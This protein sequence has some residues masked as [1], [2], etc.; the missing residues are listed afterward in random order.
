MTDTTTEKTKR[1]RWPRRLLI[2]LGVLAALIVL[3]VLLFPFISGL[4][5]PMAASAIEDATGRTAKVEALSVNLLTSRATVRGVS[6]ME[7]DGTT[8]FAGIQRLDADFGLLPLLGGRI[9]LPSVAVSGVRARVFVDEQ[10]RAN[11]QSILDHMA[12]QEDEEEDED[13][14]GEEK[15]E[16]LPD[17]QAAVRVEDVQIDYEDRRKDLAAELANPSLRCLIEGLEKISY[18][19][20]PGTVRFAAAGKPSGSGEGNW[21]VEG[22]AAVEQK[23]G[24]LAVSSEGTFE[25]SELVLRREEQIISQGKS[26]RLSHQLA[27][28]AEEGLHVSRLDLESEFLTARMSEFRFADPA[29]LPGLIGADPRVIERAGLPDWNARIEGEIRLQGLAQLLSALQ[30]APGLQHATGTIRYT[31][32]LSGRP[33]TTMR[34]DFGA[35]SDGLEV[36]ARPL[37][38][39]TSV[40]LRLVIS[41]LSQQAD[42]SVDLRTLATDG[43]HELRVTGKTKDAEL[44]TMRQKWQTPPVL[45][46]ARLPIPLNHL[47]NHLEADLSALADA[48]TGL[49]PARTRLSGRL[50]SEDTVRRD[51]DGRLSAQGR[52]ELSARLT[53]PHLPAPLPLNLSGDRRITLDQPPDG[54]LPDVTVEKLTL[55]STGSDLLHLDASGRITFSGDSPADFTLELGSDLAAAAPYL[56]LMDIPLRMQGRV[57]QNLHVESGGSTVRVTGSGGLRDLRLVGT[58]LPRP[59]TLSQARWR[60]D[61]AVL[62]EGGKPRR[63][64]LAPREKDAFELVLPGMRCTVGGTIDQI[65]L[66]AG[67]C[68]VE[69]LRTDLETDF[70]RLPRST[71]QAPLNAMLPAATKELSLGGTTTAT[72]TAS[73]NWPGRLSGRLDANLSPMTLRLLGADGQILAHKDETVP[74][75][76]NVPFSLE[77]GPDGWTALVSEL[78]ARLADLAATGRF[79]IDDRFALSGPDGG[80]RFALTAG[81]LDSL[82]QMLPPA[83]LLQPAGGAVDLAAERMR[84]A[85]ADQR[86]HGRISGEI[87]LESLS[88]ARAPELVTLLRPFLEDNTETEQPAEDADAETPEGANPGEQP[89]TSAP[90]ELPESL[91]QMLRGLTADVT[92]KVGTTHL[93][94]DDTVRDLACAINFDGKKP[95]DQLTMDLTGQV[96]PDA[97]QP[98]T[99]EAGCTADISETAPTF[100]SDYRIERLP[101]TTPMLEAGRRMTSLKTGMDLFESVR[102]DTAR[103]MSVDAVGD[104]RWRGLQWATLS[105]S[106]TS[107]GG[108]SADLPGGEFHL[109][110]DPARLL[111]SETLE[112]LTQGRLKPLTGALEKAREDKQRLNQRVENIR[113]T[114]DRI[115]GTVEKLQERR[116]NIKKTIDR[117]KPLAAFSEDAQEKLDE[118]KEKVD[119]FSGDLEK[120][121]KELGEEQDTRSK[122]QKELDRARER[123]D[124][125]QKKIENAGTGGL[126]LEKMLEFSFQGL[127]LEL[128]LENESPWPG[129]ASA[130]DLAKYAISRIR[131]KKVQFRPEKKLIPGFAGWIDLAGDYGIRIT[132]SPAALEDLEKKVPPL[133]RALREGGLVWTPT[134]LKLPKLEP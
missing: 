31:A 94:P 88:L 125:L 134:G 55:A 21:T 12:A 133:G 121:K 120:K 119:E 95:A 99:I 61:L 112:K 46:D 10:G 17:V 67:S 41:S 45:G 11:Y 29:L 68:T 115:D 100:R 102:F 37:H 105:R 44:L 56:D 24:S 3:I 1:R 2:A 93:G 66:A 104:A 75:T 16:A 5:A 81:K 108:I 32:G 118:W 15:P 122:L 30:F 33:P 116:E 117:L 8:R 65:D 6:V 18:E 50:V 111:G 63:I 39:G 127:A 113:Q 79:S 42:L 40:P 78:E 101:L 38:P 64:E 76:A 110:V 72:L 91:H 20:G 69:S 92:A 27:L 48:V 129:R 87:S 34:L 85:P 131:L 62:L 109:A 77:S 7:D 51:A 74:L 57:T 35:E 98:G 128:G 54:A 58:A 83:A 52:T 19:S 23:N 71:L 25:A 59:V 4:F 73:G 80:A 60:N 82:W 47:E 49:L 103:D 13:A 130:T 43:S 90:V 126:G 36:T 114:I 97:E 28:S 132:P 124:E 107:E 106:L 86:V 84:F 14:D 26:A 22:K 96:N 53:S 70:D 89:P 9:R 123:L